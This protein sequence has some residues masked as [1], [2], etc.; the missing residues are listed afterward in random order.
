MNIQTIQ[1][2]LSE[3][4]DAFVTYMRDLSDEAF[5][6]SAN[7]KWTPGQQLEHILLAVKPV[8][9]ACSLP[10]FLLSI[11]WGKANR[12][13]KSYDELVKKYQQKLADGGRASG[14]FVPKKVPLENK[15][16]LIENLQH[17]V[18]RLQQKLNRFSEAELD[19]YILPHP[20]LGKL[21]LREMLYFTIY[22]VAHHQQLTERDLNG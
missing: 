9:L 6:H 18:G 5:I 1:L 16:A 8:R 19:L 21:T 13:S 10:K 12:P 2:K 15:N 17:E 20:L 11:V 14:R 22:H 4:H 3:Q 7:N